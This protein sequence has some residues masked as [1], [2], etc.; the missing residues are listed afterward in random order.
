MNTSI[1]V[2]QRATV[3]TTLFLSNYPLFE[4]ISSPISTLHPPF[5]RSEGLKTLM[6]IP[7]HDCLCSIN[8]ININAIR[9]VDTSSRGKILRAKHG[10]LRLNIDKWTILIFSVLWYWWENLFNQTFVNLGKIYGSEYP[11]KI[12]SLGKRLWIQALIRWLYFILLITELGR[13]RRA[14]SCYY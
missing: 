2:G 4:A 14:C 5:M 11:R 3:F 10:Q 1:R 13:E 9:G 6:C 8:R 7:W 12:R